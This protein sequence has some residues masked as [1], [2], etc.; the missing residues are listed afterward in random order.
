MSMNAIHIEDNSNAPKRT[1]KKKTAEITSINSLG[2][3]VP[4]HSQE[5][6]IAVLGAMMLS[7]DAISRATGMLTEDAF[8]YPAHRLIFMAISALNEKG[9]T[10]DLLSLTEYL[11]S[12]DQLE[13]VGGSYYLAEI[14]MKTPTAANVEN[15][16]KIVQERYL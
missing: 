5:A 1:Y 14:N 12:K 6:E 3:K 13:Q 4:P 11:R 2:T 16:A 9:M 15:H 7:R 10:G 8:Y